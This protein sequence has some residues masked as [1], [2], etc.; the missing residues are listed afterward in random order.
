MVV[1]A[2]HTEPRAIPASTTTLGEKSRSRHNASTTST[3][4][5]ANTNAMADVA[6]G[7]MPAV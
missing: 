1:A 6:K 4:A 7:S 3:D 2:V 5:A